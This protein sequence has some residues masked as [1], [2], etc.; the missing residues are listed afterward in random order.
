MNTPT[1]RGAVT[2]RRH[3][4]GQPAAHGRRTGPDMETTTPH[5][6]LIGSLCSGYGGLDLGVQG[7]L[8]GRLAWHA[9]I[10]ADASKILA[11][12]WPSVPN[13]GDIT[14]ANWAAAPR[15]CVLTAGFPCQRRLRRR[16]QRAHPFRA[17]AACH[18]CG[19]GPPPLP[20]GG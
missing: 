5:G 3:A 17:V 16:T 13:L 1:Q 4:V 14:T 19:R 10:N 11:R 12:L 15:V 8:G 2:G 20:P 7:A 18:P 9:E 6:P